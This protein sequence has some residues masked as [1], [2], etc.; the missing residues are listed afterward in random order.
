MLFN[1]SLS[2]FSATRFLRKGYG[3]VSMVGKSIRKWWALFTL[4]TL[5][6]F[7]VGFLAPFAIGVYLSFCEFTTVS[8]AKFVGFKNYTKIF[9][10][11][12]FLHSLW[13]TVAF[14]IVTT[15][16]I[17]VASF[18]VAYMLTKAFRGANVFRSIFFM[19]NLIGGIILGY[20]WQLLLNGVLAHW[21]KSITYSETYGFWGLVILLCWQQIGYMMIIYIAGLQSLPSDVM[22]A[23][24]VDGANPR[25]TLFHVTIPLMMPSITVCT[26]LTFTNGFKLFD[27]NLALTNGAPSRASE[28]LALNIYTTFYGRTGYEGVGQA[29]AVIFFLIVA[30]VA[31]IQNKLTTSKEVSA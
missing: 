6:A 3:M 20:I 13:F 17:N 12:T 9:E 16:I 14:T 30:A 2:I 21:S 8:D 5:A 26:F 22:E 27:Q 11:G 10:D 23:A 19:P 7:I 24:Q 25:Q 31:L 1:N 28:M 4:P 29:K 15:I 18:A